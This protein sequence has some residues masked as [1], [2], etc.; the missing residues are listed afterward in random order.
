MVSHVSCS[1]SCS[2]FS[3]FT[4]WIW[5][6]ACPILVLVRK[7]YRFGCFCARDSLNKTPSCMFLLF[8]S[9][10]PFV[11]RSCL[12]LWKKSLLSLGILNRKI[13]HFM[14]LLLICKPIKLRVFWDAFPQHNP[15]QRSHGLAYLTSLMAHVQSF[16]V[17][18]TKC[19]WSF[20]FILIDI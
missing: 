6:Q 15:N 12:Q 4:I 5:N 17:L 10:Y 13:K 19:I 20:D 7:S 8:C 18:S 1:C 2:C 9:C 14:N 11:S 16:V 3:C